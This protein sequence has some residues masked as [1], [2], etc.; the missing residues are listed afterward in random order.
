MGFNPAIHQGI[1]LDVIMGKYEEMSDA[2]FDLPHSGWGTM[3]FNGWVGADKL[4]ADGTIPINVYFDVWENKGA[5]IEDP[6]DPRD[7]YTLIGKSAIM[8]A[9]ADVTHPGAVLSTETAAQSID[10]FYDVY[11][12]PSGAKYIAPNK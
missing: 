11:G 3:I 9:G 2:G 1:V 7:G 12:I 6:A 8:I 4:N 5:V 10:F